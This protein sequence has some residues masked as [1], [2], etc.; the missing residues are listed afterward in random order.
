MH[1]TCLILHPNRAPLSIN[2]DWPEE[3]SYEQIKPFTDEHIENY[4]ERV[5]IARGD[6][7]TD[8]LVDEEG[9]L[10]NLPINKI[11]SLFYWGPI[12]GPKSAIFGPAL[13]FTRPVIF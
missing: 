11:A 9:L 13:I 2:L 7:Y 8:M 10:K 5:K 3:P 4:F 1:T 6:S 12:G